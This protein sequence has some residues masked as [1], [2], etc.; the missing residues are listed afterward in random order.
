MMKLSKGISPKVYLW[1]I[2]LSVFFVM[3][4]GTLL[5]VLLPI[6]QTDLQINM[7]QS[8]WI[9]NGY[10]LPFALLMP[11]VGILSKRIANERMFFIG[12]LLFG[13]GA[14]CG[15]L[16]PSFL[17]LLLSRIIQ[18]IGSSIIVPISLVLMLNQSNKEGYTKIIGIWGAIGALAASV[19]PIL[20]GVIGQFGNWKIVFLINV[21]VFFVIF[22]F[23]AQIQQQKD[24]ELFGTLQLKDLFKRSILLYTMLLNFG[25]G[26]I[27][28]SIL[29]VEPFILSTF[30]DSTFGIAVGVVPLCISII[31]AAVII[32][33]M[34]KKV[35]LVTLAFA[36]VAFLVCSLLVIILTSNFGLFS[37]AMVNLFVGLGLGLIIISSTSQAMIEMEIKHHSFISS[38]INM[39]RLLG[40]VIGSTIS[41]QIYRH[42]ALSGVNNGA[43]YFYT[44]LLLPATLL[45][46]VLIVQLYWQRKN[47]SFHN[48]QEK[49]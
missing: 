33:R 2:G 3:Q 15:A 5:Y 31:L 48:V 14:L 27:L 36:G 21:L 23:T 17:S 46:L 38:M 24:T 28:N 32:R 45:M 37:L 26:F 35:S 11:L 47:K 40:A 9:M 1:I 7:S 34:E 4:D 44:S 18:G 29:Y 30:I 20:G 25:V 43:N 39:S 8:I 6:I 49:M 12:V 41:S 16:S 13:C 22:L 19:G 10:I 42:Y